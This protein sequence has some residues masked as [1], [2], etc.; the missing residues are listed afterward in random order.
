[1]MLAW[2][3]LVKGSRRWRFVKAE[4]PCMK[5]EIQVSLCGLSVVFG[6]QRRIA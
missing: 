2:M 6:W 4:P 1:M 5:G 3:I